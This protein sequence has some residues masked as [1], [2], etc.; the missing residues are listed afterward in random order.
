MPSPRRERPS[1]KNNA[2]QIGIIGEKYTTNG[3]RDF[4][5]AVAMRDHSV[6]ETMR[7]NRSHKLAACGYGLRARP[8][9][10]RQRGDDP[11]AGSRALIAGAP[12]SRVIYRSP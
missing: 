1:R 8:E 7:A 10:E 5:L 11:F 9:P 12:V 4:P 2:N 3:Q 6:D